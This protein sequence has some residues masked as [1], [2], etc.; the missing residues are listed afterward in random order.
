M[1]QPTADPTQLR[2]SQ[3]EREPQTA[4]PTQLRNSQ[5]ERAPPPADQ[6]QVAEGDHSPS[7]YLNLEQT[8]ACGGDEVTHN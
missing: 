1:A 2:N 3:E 4:D 6:A 5:E 7:N 8:D